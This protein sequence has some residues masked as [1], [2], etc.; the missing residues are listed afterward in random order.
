[1]DC[2]G[3]NGNEAVDDIDFGDDDVEELLMKALLFTTASGQM[4]PLLVL[5]VLLMLLMRRINDA[6]FSMRWKSAFIKG[7]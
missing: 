4:L 1:M 2:I 5:L 3:E 6:P 7:W